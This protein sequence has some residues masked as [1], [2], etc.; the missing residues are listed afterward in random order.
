V[1][2]TNTNLPPLKQ[3]HGSLRR[4]TERLARELA[5]PGDTA[6]EWSGLDWQLARAVAALHGISPLLA[7]KLRWSGPPDWQEF[8][9]EQRGHVAAR[10]RRIEQLLSQLD[11]RAREAAVGIVG[12]KGAALHACGL[13][14]A[15]ERP[16]ADIDLLVHPQQTA[17]ATGLLESLGYYER[18]A[19]RRHKVFMPE[20]AAQTA[21]VGEHADNY[22]KIELHEQIGECLPCRSVDITALVRPRDTHPGLVGYPS[23]AAMLS[24]LLIHAAGAMSFRGVRLLHLNDLALVASSMSNADWQE[25][26]ARATQSA[27]AWWAL[28]PL[29]L[30]ARYFE[31]AIPAEVLKGLAA[32]CPW[33]LRRIAY[34]R[35]VSD[36]SF[37]FLWMEAFPAIGWSRS[38]SEALEYMSAR[39]RPDREAR[40]LRQMLV[41]TQIAVAHSPWGK[42]NQG[43]RIVRWL[44]S[45]QPRI[46]T[47]HA[48]RSVLQ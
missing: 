44:T 17:R 27:T 23:R 34:R 14:R 43:Q 28:P 20:V 9:T 36:A 25:L 11:V 16:M 5:R 10:H 29:Q 4:I 6:P 47:L 22:L 31:I 45:R 32:V 37:S 13:Y 18:Y 2:E 42:L 1:G 7:T 24:H 35:S 39:I 46:D 12:L 38:I 21:A 26:L 33:N 41:E 19:T 3:L 48:V 8:L 40:R 30:T 15:G